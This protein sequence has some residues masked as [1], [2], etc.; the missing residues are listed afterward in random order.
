MIDLDNR[1]EIIIQEKTTS[2]INLPTAS[3]FH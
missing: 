1:E 2:F 3:I